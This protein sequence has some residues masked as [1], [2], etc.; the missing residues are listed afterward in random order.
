MCTHSLESQL[1]TGLHKMK[2]GQQVKGYSP[3]LVLSCETP[4]G[5]LYPALESSR[6]VVA[7]P[8]KGYKDDQR[9]ETPLLLRQTERAGLFS[10]EM[11]SL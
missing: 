5:V 6:P 1:C 9:A 8:D 11:R 7:G 3:P 2:H 10:L 4:S